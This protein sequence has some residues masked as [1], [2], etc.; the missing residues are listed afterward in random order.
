METACTQFPFP[1]YP[2]RNRGPSD[3]TGARLGG[4]P[5]GSGEG[6]YE[7]QGPSKIGRGQSEV[8]RSTSRGG[9]A[10]GLYTDLVG[11]GP[12][13]RIDP[14]YFFLFR[15]ETGFHCVA[16][17]EQRSIWLCFLSAGI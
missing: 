12:H 15:F 7:H 17:L 13:S 14:V 16:G 8:L 2:V 3:G 6:A 5:P 4:S 1:F 9:E 11:S 10:P